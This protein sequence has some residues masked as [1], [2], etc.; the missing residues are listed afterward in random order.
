MG[1]DG[2]VGQGH[3]ITGQRTDTFTA[4]GVAF[5]RHGAGTDLFFAEG[6]FH[7]PQVGQQTDIVGHFRGGTGKTGQGRHHIIIHLTG[8]GLAGNRH[9]L[10]KAH[11][12]GHAAFQFFNF[13]VVAVKESEE[14]C[15]SAGGPLHAAERQI[16]QLECQLFIVHQEIL[17]IQRKTFADRSQLSHL[18]VGETQRGHIRISPAELPHLIHEFQEFGLNEFQTV[19]H[20]NELRVIR[21]IAAGGPQMDHRHGIRTLGPE[22]VDMAHHVM[23]QF[24]F[25][26]FHSGKVDIFQMGGH[27]LDLGIGDRQTQSFFFGSEGEPEFTP[28]GVFELGTPEITH[29]F[30]GIAAGQ[31]RTVNV[32]IHNKFLWF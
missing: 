26:G 8:I 2:V 25:F 27:L 9:D 32:M 3:Q 24:F 19:L 6:F 10:I 28:G 18:I 1:I 12:F 23:A 5:V 16:F 20:L 13:F 30:A 7:F 17:Q 31:R 15:L 11:A 29:L 22:N 4:H 21:H 14:T